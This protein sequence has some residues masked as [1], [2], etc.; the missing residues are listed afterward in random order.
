MICWCDACMKTGWILFILLLT[1]L[2]L[3]GTVNV[4]GAADQ[5]EAPDGTYR[6]GDNNAPKSNISK[7][8]CDFCMS[9]F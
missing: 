6:N 8:H 9:F 1:C 2:S 7:D 3:N 5:L 4:D